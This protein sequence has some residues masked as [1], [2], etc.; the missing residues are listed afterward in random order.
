AESA[1][2][3]TGAGHNLDHPV[4]GWVERIQLMPELLVFD[5][6]L[7]PG[8][9]GN[10]LHGDDIKEFRKDKEKWVRFSVAD[11]LGNEKMLERRVIDK[12]TFRTTSGKTERRYIIESAICMEKVYLVL[13][14]ALADRSDYE[15]KVRIGRES[16]A[17]NF[18][19]D[20]ARTRTASPDC[21]RS[22]RKSK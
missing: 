3:Q 9:E 14:F 11:A 15:Q 10:V 18:L 17:G 20:P 1:K 13:E 7:T 4:L 8:S 6:K 21:G 2:A 19:V 5:A 22:K 16:L 12:S